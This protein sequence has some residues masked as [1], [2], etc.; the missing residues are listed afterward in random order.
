MS[1]RF[2]NRVIANPAFLSPMAGYTN[3]PFRVLCQHHGCDVTITEFV[4]ALSL[5]KKPGLAPSRSKEEKV[6]G[7]QLFGSEPQAFIDI[8]DLVEPSFDFIDVN[9][10]CPDKKINRQGSCAALLNHPG[11]MA[12]IIKALKDNSSKP[13]TCKIRLG[14]A[15]NDSID[16]VNHLVKANVDAVFVHGRTVKQFYSGQADWLAIGTIAK[17]YPSLTLI[18]NGDIRSKEDFDAKMELSGCSFGLIGRA[19]IKNPLIFEEILSGKK[20]SWQERVNLIPEYAAIADQYGELELND[21]KLKVIGAL[22]GL[23]HAAQLRND[24]A[25]AKS[26]E[27]IHEVV[28]GVSKPLN[29]TE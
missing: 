15:S 1:F 9:F 3:R 23:P 19:A 20:S 7:I 24:I 6:A 29:A 5:E 28:A 12:A 27:G 16:I 26:V 21:L 10:G 14:I 2:L 13:I 17:E 25:Q 11:Q 22:H 18:G 8:L 4:S